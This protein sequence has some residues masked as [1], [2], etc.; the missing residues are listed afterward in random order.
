MEKEKAERYKKKKSSY[1]SKGIINIFNINSKDINNIKNIV[2][3][4]VD[5]AKNMSVYNRLQREIEN[6]R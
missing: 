5:K 6:E 2:G 3:K 1:Q 4:D